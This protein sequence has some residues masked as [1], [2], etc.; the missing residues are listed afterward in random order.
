MTSG[1]TLLILSG[2]APA[3]DAAR[4]AKEMG[5]AVVML[6]ADTKALGFAFADS[7]LIANVHQPVESAA[8]AER[9]SRKIR[10]IDGVI[11]IGVQAPV[12]AATVAARL[13]LPGMP[14]HV[15]ELIGDRLAARKCFVS[16][17]IA[18]PWFAEIRT[19]QELQRAVIAQGR[20]LLI[21]PPDGEDEAGAQHLGD[22]ED[23]AVSFSHARSHSPSERVMV[24]K[25][26]SGPRLFSETL[27]SA[28][29]CFTP[30]IADQG[31]DGASRQSS[32][33]LDQARALAARSASALGLSDGTLAAEMMLDDGQLK[34]TD[35]SA[36]LSGDFCTREIPRH[37]GVDFVGAAIRLALGE[38]LAGA[39]L[40]PGKR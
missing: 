34:L 10:K 39:D 19:L 1:K 40:M 15:A 7:C 36:S 20:D 3:A 2:G 23:L 38:T 35:F 37:T 28:G 30:L 32:A 27:V 9:Y 24:E 16:A 14:V 22:V 4:R 12:T 21:T 33:I 31:R 26:P 18:S 11:G 6:D 29:Q 13:R 5:L 17:G 25:Y 8:A